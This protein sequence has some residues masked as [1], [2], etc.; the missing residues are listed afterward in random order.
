MADGWETY[1]VEF[2]GGLVTNLAPIQQ[3]INMPGSARQL[4]NFEP[5]VSGGYRRVSGYAKYAPNAL[6]GA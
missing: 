5:S 1:P 6:T 2:R 4:R 3:G